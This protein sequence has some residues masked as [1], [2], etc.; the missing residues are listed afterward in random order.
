MIMNIKQRKIKIE[1]RIKLNYNIHISVIKL[2]KRK[3]FQV[4]K[5]KTNI[6]LLK[7]A[8]RDKKI[9]NKL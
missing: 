3:K 2:R 5:K 7:E 4:I 9:L 6:S 8:Y 1:P